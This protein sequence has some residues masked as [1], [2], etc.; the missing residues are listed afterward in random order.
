MGSYNFIQTQPCP[1]LETQV[2]KTGS[3]RGVLDPSPESRV[4]SLDGRLSML[5]LHCDNRLEQL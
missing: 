4:E 2:C 5:L 3:P 1:L